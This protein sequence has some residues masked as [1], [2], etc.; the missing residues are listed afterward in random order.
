MTHTN[1][2]HRW[3]EQL[4]DLC[5]R[6]APR[7]ARIEPRLRARAYLRGLLAPL[8]R[9]NGCWGGRPPYGIAVPE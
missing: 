7:F 3:D 6:I 9:K 8:K 4:D 5:I 2:A 1:E